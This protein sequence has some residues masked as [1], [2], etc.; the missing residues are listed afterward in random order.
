MSGNIFGLISNLHCDNHCLDDLLCKRNDVNRVSLILLLK[1]GV[2]NA[3]V[4]SGTDINPI[5]YYPFKSFVS[6]NEK[7]H[8]AGSNTIPFSYWLLLCLERVTKLREIQT[9]ALCYNCNHKNGA[10]RDLNNLWSGSTLHEVWKPAKPTAVK[11]V[12]GYEA[13]C[14]VYLQTLLPY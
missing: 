4:S 6:E 9:H 10:S 11:T 14:F 13:T 12:W 1:Y 8:L 5:L 7:R 3:L 2:W